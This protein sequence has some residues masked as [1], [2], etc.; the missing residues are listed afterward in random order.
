MREQAAGCIWPCVQWGFH[1]CIQM[2]PPSL[3]CACAPSHA[4]WLPKPRARSD[5]R[6]RHRHAA[7]TWLLLPA[8]HPPSQ[9]VKQAPTCSWGWQLR[10]P[11]RCGQVEPPSSRPPLR[12]RR[13]LHSRDPAPEVQ[14]RHRGLAPCSRQVGVGQRGSC[15]SWRATAAACSRRGQC[16]QRRGLCE[17]GARVR[18]VREQAAGCIW[19]CVQ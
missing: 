4:P 19:P 17:R 5:G 8:T 10:R 6:P 3:S 9:P 16:G 18:R 14:A 2:P 15:S 7:H 12:H 1:A 11:G 13:P